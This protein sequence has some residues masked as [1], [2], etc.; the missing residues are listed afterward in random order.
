MAPGSASAMSCTPQTAG[1]QGA[2][3]CTDDAGIAPASKGTLRTVGRSPRQSHVSIG[4][5]SSVRSA[6]AASPSAAKAPEAGSSGSSSAVA[7]YA[8]TQSS[9]ICAV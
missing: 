2:R 7:L 1:V 6:T 8:R 3:C 4:G 9:T 5:S